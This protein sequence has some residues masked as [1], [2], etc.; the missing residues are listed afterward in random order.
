VIVKFEKRHTT[1]ARDGSLAANIFY[2]QFMNTALIALIVSSV[3]YVYLCVWERRREREGIRVWERICVC[4]GKKEYMYVYIYKYTLYICIYTYI[5]VY[6][7]IHKHAIAWTASNSD[8]LNH[9]PIL[10]DKLNWQCYYNITKLHFW[11]MMW[12][13]A[14]T[15]A[16]HCN[17]LVTHLQHVA[18]LCDTLQHTATHCNTLHL[19]KHVAGD[20]YKNLIWE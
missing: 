8:N 9:T 11:R 17:T 14:P 16:T 3:M 5:Y 7:Y 19:A 4:T 20:H 18:T 15:P 1:N 12:V 13:Y 10:Y 2:A 6:I